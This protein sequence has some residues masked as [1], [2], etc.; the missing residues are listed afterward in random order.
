VPPSPS[1]SL[2]RASLA[3]VQTMESLGLDMDA[4]VGLA[5]G[6]PPP[7]APS[8]PRSRRPP[9]VDTGSSVRIWGIRAATA[10]ASGAGDEKPS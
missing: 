7:R 6:G 4:F 2:T 10:E 8:L 3:Q 9:S 5:S 1:K